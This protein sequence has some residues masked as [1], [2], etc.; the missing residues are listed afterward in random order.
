MKIIVFILALILALSGCNKPDE[1]AVL[2]TIPEDENISEPEE[3]L[4]NSILTANSVF[5]SD[6]NGMDF[7]EDRAFQPVIET[8]GNLYESP[9]S[10]H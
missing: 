8:G 7:P 4:K 2:E 9:Q 1:P 6:A 5:L 10:D 3:P